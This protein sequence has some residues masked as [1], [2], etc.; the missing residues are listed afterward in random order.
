MRNYCEL[1]FVRFLRR[2]LWLWAWLP[3]YLLSCGKGGVQVQVDPDARLLR[4][5]LIASTTGSLS[6]ALSARAT[7]YDRM[8]NESLLHR[9]ALTRK[10]L[11]GVSS[12]QP[13]EVDTEVVSL[14]LDPANLSLAGAATVTLSAPSQDLP[15]VAFSLSAKSVGSVQVNGLDETSSSSYANETLTITPASPFTAGTPLTV[16]IGWSDADVNVTVDYSPEGGSNF[17]GSLL[18]ENSTF[19]A[20]DYQFWPWLVGQSIMNNLTFQ[21][22]YPADQTLVMSGARSASVVSGDGQ[23]K[24]DTWNIT[25][26][27]GGVSL[28]LAKYE[29]A[30]GQCGN[31]VIEIYAI[32]GKSI[33]NYPIRPST[34]GPVLSSYC[35]L[36]R[37]WFGEP[38][39]DTISFAGVDERFTSGVSTPGLVIVPNYTWDDDGNGSFKERD[40]FLVHELAHQWWGN[41]VFI[42]SSADL[43]LQEGMA[44]FAAGDAVDTIRG[45]KDGQKIW[46]WEVQ[47]LLSYYQ[48]GGTDYPLVPE[49]IS[50]MEPRI[51]YI[52][53]AWVLRMLESV[54]GSETLFGGLKQFRVNHPFAVATTDE[55]KN[56]MVLTAGQNLDWFFNEWLYG[57]GLLSLSEKHTEKA[58]DIKVTITQSKPWAVNPDQYFVMPIPVRIKNNGKS[59]DESLQLTGIE[60]T[61]SFSLP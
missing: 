13:V 28:A 3:L 42:A 55:F 36:Y 51:Y 39:F 16:E 40:F 9:S 19:F 45:H 22:T 2:S 30:T 37:T 15:N 61:T 18:N 47:P 4:D 44:D 27:F 24:T 46:L 60:S 57:L 25:F 43:W 8:R 32:P 58:G 59:N 10:I 29:T 54:I 56:L 1:E 49:D 20:L 31:T 11:D 23:S 34:Y 35:D 21:V 48:N 41:D 17:I 12:S 14:T 7:R 33:D 53:G 26:P 6:S 50:T 5:D 38:A 52:K